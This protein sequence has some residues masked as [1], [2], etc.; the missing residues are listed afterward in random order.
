MTVK[1]ESIRLEAVRYATGEEQRAITTSPKTM[2]WQ[3]RNS[4]QLWVCLVLKVKRD[5]VK[6]SM[7]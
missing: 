4:A 1:D 5:A 2:K 7:A 3:S 6:K